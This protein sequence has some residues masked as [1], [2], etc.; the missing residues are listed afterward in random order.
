MYLRTMKK[1]ACEFSPRRHCRMVLR[2]RAYSSAEEE[3]STSSSW[4]VCQNWASYHNLVIT[5]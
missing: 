2:G 1:L 3:F 4:T 5:Y